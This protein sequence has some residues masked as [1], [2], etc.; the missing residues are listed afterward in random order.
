MEI[1]E[2]KKQIL[3]IRDN[4]GE[5]FDRYTIVLNTRFTHSRPTF[6]CIGQSVD[7]IGYDQMGEALPGEHLGKLIAWDD[8]PEGNRDAL[9]ARFSLEETS[10]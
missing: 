10:C 3:E 8:L 2:I 1:N 9:I 7:A 5:T 6:E 4:G